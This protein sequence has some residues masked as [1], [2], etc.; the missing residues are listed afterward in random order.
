M[1]EKTLEGCAFIKGAEEKV[2]LIRKRLLEAYSISFWH[3]G[4][5]NEY[6][7]K[8]EKELRKKK[9]ENKK[10]KENSSPPLG[11]VDSGPRAPLSRAR[12]PPALGPPSP[13]RPPLSLSLGPTRQPRPAMLSHARTPSRKWAS[14]VSP[15][16]S[17]VTSPV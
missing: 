14:P 3:L 8:G 13:A 17:P 12:L 2:A 7:Y 10:K 4:N 15:F 6:L 5:I 11:W 9:R 16:F 1:G